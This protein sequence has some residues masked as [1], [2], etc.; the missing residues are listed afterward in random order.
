MENDLLYQDA[1]RLCS[2]IFRT[3]PTSAKFAIVNIVRSDK[4]FLEFG[5]YPEIP[6]SFGYGHDEAI[7]LLE[8]HGVVEAYASDRWFR[9]IISIH[10]DDD[11]WEEYEIHLNAPDWICQVAERKKYI[12]TLEGVRYCRGPNVPGHFC[13]LANVHSLE[14]F[15]QIYSGMKPIFDEKTGEFRYKGQRVRFSGEIEQKTV[16]LLID[17]VGS[18]VTNKELYELRGHTNYLYYEENKKLTPIHDVIEKCVGKIKKRI[19]SNRIMKKDLFFQ[20]NKGHG[21]F[22]R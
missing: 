5:E 12:G 8:E 16:K 1:V 15:V 11:Y 18:I 20:Q 17:N 2:N 3:T 9:D 21:L 14:K 13:I 7:H 6:Q 10:E 22:V 4:D 19:L